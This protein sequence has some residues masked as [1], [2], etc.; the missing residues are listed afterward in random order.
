MRNPAQKIALGNLYSVLGL[1][2]QYM[3]VGLAPTHHL[4]ESSTSKVS[5][6][7]NILFLL[8][9][10]SRGLYLVLAPPADNT[11]GP[12]VVFCQSGHG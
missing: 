3:N 10:R 1:C 4:D 12:E 8:Y 11:S 2:Y 5:N 6:P 9:M 7:S